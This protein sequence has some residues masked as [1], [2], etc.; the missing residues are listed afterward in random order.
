MVLGQ[1]FCKIAYS[2]FLW[3]YVVFFSCNDHHSFMG[4][5]EDASLA[6]P[7]KDEKSIVRVVSL[8]QR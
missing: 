3:S 2:W 4:A 1:L 6:T 7:S 5:D 8:R